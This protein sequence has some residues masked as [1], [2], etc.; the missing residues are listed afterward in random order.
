[1]I[2]FIKKKI[3]CSMWGIFNILFNHIFSLSRLFRNNIKIFLVIKSVICSIFRKYIISCLKECLKMHNTYWLRC[4]NH[5]VFSYNFP[6]PILD[7]TNQ[8]TSKGVL[9]LI[10]FKS[11]W[12]WLF[13]FLIILLGLVA[14]H[15]Y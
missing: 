6:Q 8:I 11:D 10:K 7:S 15:Y 14:E 5:F 2:N 13:N 9:R 12:L 3:F 4:L 1:M